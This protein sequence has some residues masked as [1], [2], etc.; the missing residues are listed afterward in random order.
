[1]IIIDEVSVVSNI[2]LLHIHQ[3]L[4]EIFAAPT[5]WLF[6][7]LNVIVVGDLHQLGPIRS[8]LIFANYSDDAYNISSLG[9]FCNDRIDRKYETERWLGI[10]QTLQQVQNSIT[11]WRR[12]CDYSVKVCKSNRSKLP[13]ACFT[14]LGWECSSWR[15]QQ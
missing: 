8:G 4:Q 5:N 3:R 12:Y 14:Y 9:S 7:G 13:I 2:T 10:Y 15:K 11:D 6:A 1:M